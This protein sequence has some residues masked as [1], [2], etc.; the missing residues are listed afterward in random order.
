MNSVI[1]SVSVLFIVAFALAF[2]AEA[3]TPD[4]G[5]IGASYQKGGTPSTAATG[6]YAKATTEDGSTPWA[7]TVVDA[8]PVAGTKALTF[9]TNIGVG[10]AERVATLGKVGVF[11]PTSAGISWSGT[12]TGWQASTGALFAVPIGRGLILAPNVRVLKSSVSNGAGYQPVFG[13]LFGW[14]RKP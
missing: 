2:S 11:V 3:Q 10:I 13:V 4:F 7:F 9:T 5:A 8:L 14:Q 6:L 12:N 1:R